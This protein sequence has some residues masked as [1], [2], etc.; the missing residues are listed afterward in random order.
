MQLTN[1]PTNPTILIEEHFV[2]MP[3][4]IP[5]SGTE[6]SYRHYNPLIICF[7][8]ISS[9]HLEYSFNGTPLLDCLADIGLSDP[10]AP[11]LQDELQK[12]RESIRFVL[13]VVSLRRASVHSLTVSPVAWI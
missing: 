7:D 1:Q 8:P 4:Y 3:V 9:E 5:P 11:V 13:K 12:G 2:P 6:S 10:D